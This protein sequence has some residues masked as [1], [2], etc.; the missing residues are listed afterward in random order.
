[1]DRSESVLDGLDEQQRAAA[2]TLRGPVAILAG[3]GTG[4]TRTITHRIAH[5]VHTGTYSPDRVLAVSFTKKAAGELQERLYQLGVI[6]VQTRTFH[7]AALQQ[8]G[9]FWPQ[10]IGGEAPKIIS[11][12]M[13][14]LT[15]VLAK[16]GIKLGGEA[17]RDLAAELEW[18][19]VSLLTYDEYLARAEERPCI[20]ELDATKVVQIANQYEQVKKDR[21]SIDFEDVILLLTGMLQEEPRVAATVQ[22]RYRFFTVDEYQDVSPLQNALLT[23]W[24]G[25]RK[26]LCVVGDVSQ[27]I[28]SFAGASSGY[29]RSFTSQ[30]AGAKEF[31]LEENY[32]SAPEIITLANNLMKGQPGA[33]TLHATRATKST[34]PCYEWFETEKEEAAGVAQAIADKI[35]SGTP[36]SSIAILYRSHSYS[37]ALESALREARVNIRVQ[38][39]TRFFDRADVKR[40]VMEIRAQSLTPDGRPIFQVVS[41]VIRGQGWNSK[42][43]EGGTQERENWEVLGSLL[44]LVDEMLPNMTIKEFSDELQRR[45]KSDHEPTLDAVTLATVHSAKGLEWPIVWLVG[46][47][48][49][50]FPITFAKT[51]EAIDEERRL[52]Y[53]A[54]TRARDE[55]YFSGSGKGNKS[56]SRFLAEAKVPI[57]GES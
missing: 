24:L 48:E 47:S 6:G 43:P 9:H 2:T 8:L 4:K 11:S 17:T 25:E 12:K 29:L 22:E 27:T 13:Q 44:N 41:D 51:A 54:I 55:I 16:M 19:K 34:Q 15:H 7:S 3:A 50:S 35:R 32:R 18:R 1:M 56:P 21:H 23:A 28:Y 20:A 49:G 53:V 42:P 45:S 26:D 5:G 38:A 36:A 40:A 33:L 37:L 52:F 14:T 10:T 46:A 39:G 31:R 57:F 30:F